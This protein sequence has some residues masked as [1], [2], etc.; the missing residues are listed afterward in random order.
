MLADPEHTS[1]HP[2]QYCEMTGN[3]SYYRD[4]HKLVTLH[5]PGTPYDDSEWALYDIR[6]DP[7]EIHDLSAEHPGLVKELSAAWEKAAWRNGVFPLPD[8]SGALA[9]RNPAE[10]RLSRPLTL[11]PGTPELERYRSSRLVALR[12]FEIA[13]AIDET[14]EGVLV[15]H[16]DQGGGYSLYVEDGRLRL[17][18]N[19]YGVLHESDAGP[20]APGEHLVVLAATAEQ[21][22]RW[23]FTVSVDGEP[24]AN[25]RSV[26]Q[27][28]GMAPFQ[29]ISVGIDRKSPVS[30]PLF[31]RHHSF[32]FQGRLR[33]VTYRP[34]DPGPDSPETVAAALKEAAA[35]FE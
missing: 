33:S 31:E 29:G 16:G 28:I 14:G 9:R 3:R 1:T 32:P 26:H 5:R 35:A 20:L 12:S 8:G 34:G 4:G 22:L 19:E 25:P 17:A 2:E 10:R 7:T 13:V 15:S 11:L 27:L 30:W 23:S 24:R 6:A 18:Y 21:G